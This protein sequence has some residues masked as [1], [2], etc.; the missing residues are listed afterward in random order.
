[1]IVPAH[2]GLMVWMICEEGQQ[3]DAG[4]SSARRKVRDHWE[5]TAN[6]LEIKRQLR[7]DGIIRI[8]AAIRE[9][10]IRK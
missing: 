9:P 7:N 2:N 4:C 3:T 6:I 10:R 8:N 1:M 5:W